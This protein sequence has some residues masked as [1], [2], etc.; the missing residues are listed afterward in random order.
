MKTLTKKT[1]LA[2]ETEDKLNQQIK[3]EAESSQFYLACASWCEKEG[4]VGAADFLYQ[5]ADEERMHMMKIFKYVNEAGGHALAPEIHDMRHHFT[6]LREVFEELLEHEIKV[7]TAIN[8]LADHCFQFKDFASFQ[9]L[10]WFVMEQ[11]EEEELSRRAIEIFDLIG[12]D[13]PQGLWLIDQELGKL[14][15]MML[16]KEAEKDAQA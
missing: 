1:S 5:H 2:I 4:Y 14:H 12:E 15:Q 6:S 13:T 9:F 16:A 3:M 7:T 10:Q 11:R 8:D